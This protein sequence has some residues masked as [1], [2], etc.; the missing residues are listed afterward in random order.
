MWRSSCIVSVPVRSVQGIGQGYVLSGHI[1]YTWNIWLF[2]KVHQG[3][4]VL[5]HE[6]LWW[7]P[8]PSKCNDHEH[9]QAL[10]GLYLHSGCVCMC[11][12]SVYVM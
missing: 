3:A 5:V 7:Q 4:L 11:V 2:S 6:E 12:C 9:Q 8:C 10:S 1:D